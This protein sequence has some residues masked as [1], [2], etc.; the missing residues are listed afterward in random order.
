MKRRKGE[1]PYDAFL[2]VSF[3]GPEGKDEVMPFLDNVLRGKNVPLERKQV[4]AEH[5]WRFGG[6]SPI[7]QENRNL[8]AALKPHV[9]QAGARLPIYWGNRNWHPLLVD[10]VRQMAY[11]GVKKALAF[12]TAAYGSYSSCR[13]YQENI[14]AACQA[15]GAQ[16]PQ[17][18]KIRPFFNHPG[19]VEANADNL[20][21]ALTQMPSSKRE[22]VQVVFTAHSIPQSMADGCPYVTQLL[23]ACRLVAEAAGCPERWQLAYQSRSG[24]PSQPWLEPDI[25]D[26]IR[27]FKKKGG[28]DLVVCPIGFLSDHMEVVYDLDVEAKG[29][30]TALGVNL[31]RTPTAGSHARFIKM[32]QELIEERLD[33]SLPRQALGSYGPYSEVCREDCCPIAQPTKVMKLPI[34]REKS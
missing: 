1:R 12:V 7:N 31:I 11:D 28:E 8:I 3:G 4:V 22:D 29:L 27:S 25:L 6:I 23:E 13:Q 14:L 16:A 19:F 20:S 21:S 32:V 18:D 17:I 24:L 26:C 34:L 33:P 15:V 2:L 5:Y 10:T 9:E 30:S